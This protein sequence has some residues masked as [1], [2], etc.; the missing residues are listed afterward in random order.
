[1]ALSRVTGCS[2]PEFFF[3][4]VTS[5]FAGKWSCLP[6]TGFT[7]C[8]HCPARRPRPHCCA[9]CLMDFSRCP[10]C[11]YYALHRSPLA[12]GVNGTEPNSHQFD[13]L[14]SSV[15]GCSWILLISINFALVCHFIKISFNMNNMLQWGTD[16]TNWRQAQISREWFS[17]LADKFSEYHS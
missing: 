14:F 15:T 4:A 16:W 13:L 12:A 8:R 2:A 17:T 3:P 9:V 6:A 1:M 5:N 7:H 10:R 11:N